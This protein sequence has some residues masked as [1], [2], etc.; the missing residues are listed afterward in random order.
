MRINRLN[1][2]PSS[3][4]GLRCCH[5]PSWCHGVD[6]E[7]SQDAPAEYTDRARANWS[8]LAVVS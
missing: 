8:S 3:A 7:V 5:V 4:A 2:D 6:D 1:A